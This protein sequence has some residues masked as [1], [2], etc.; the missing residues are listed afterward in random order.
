MRALAQAGD[1]DDTLPKGATEVGGRPKD[2][3]VA[4]DKMVL[5][6]Y[7]RPYSEAGKPTG[8]FYKHARAERVPDWLH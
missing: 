6:S 8:T 1:F 2:S 4:A 5:Q 7:G 3:V